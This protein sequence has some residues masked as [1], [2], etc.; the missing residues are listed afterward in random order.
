MF[1]WYV[2]IIYRTFP[3][4][5]EKPHAPGLFY[6]FPISVLEKKNSERSLSPS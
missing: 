1:F 6:A 5:L 2:P 4:F 3:D